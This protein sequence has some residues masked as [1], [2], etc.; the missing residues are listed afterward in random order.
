MPET[1]APVYGRGEAV[2][3]RVSTAQLLGQVSFLV[4]AALGFCSLGTY[5]GRDLS[6]GTATV[7]FFVA[8]GML[9]ASSFAGRRFRV[10]AVAIGWLYAIALLLG[11]GLGPTIRYF[12]ETNQSAL[13]TAAG[14]TALTVV[15]MGSLGFLL[16]KDL[17]RWMRPL[18]LIVFVAAIVSWGLLIFGS[19]GSYPVLSAIIGLA[20][21]ALI[22]VDFNYLRKHGTEEDAV[23][24]AT[25]I[26]IS[27]L[28][29]FLSLLNIFSGR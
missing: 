22:A 2:A 28:N 15:A 27:I 11:L 12:A 26:F 20:S 9:F 4:A 19:T 1:T 29:I 17:A 10:G 7:L 6:T 14:A 21:A 5:I 3:G 16:A 23:W 8:I 18:T 25:G 13:T 24:L